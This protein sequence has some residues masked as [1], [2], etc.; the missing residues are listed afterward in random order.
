MN[1]PRSGS[2]RERVLLKL[3]EFGATGATFEQL[4]TATGIESAAKRLTELVQGGWAFQTKTTRKTH[5]GASATVHIVSQLALQELER[6]RRADQTAGGGSASFHDAKP[7]RDQ[8]P[9]SGEGAQPSAVHDVEPTGLFGDEPTELR[10]TSHY[11]QVEA[12]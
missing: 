12:A 1:L 7:V 8:T 10:S 4:A 5:T 6:E 9:P 2:Q 11:S 3:V